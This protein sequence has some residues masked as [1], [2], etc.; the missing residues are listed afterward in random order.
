MKKS[1]L[2]LLLCV[3]G[4]YLNPV[5]AQGEQIPGGGYEWCQFINRPDKPEIDGC[6]VAYF[7]HICICE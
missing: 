1:I 4:F 7:N 6:K 3:F 2:F 5:Q